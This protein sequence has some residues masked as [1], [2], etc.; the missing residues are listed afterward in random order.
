MQAELHAKSDSPSLGPAHVPQNMVQPPQ[1]Q[2]PIANRQSNPRKAN[3]AI[4]PKLEPSSAGTAPGLLHKSATSPKNRP[5]PSSLSDSPGNAGSTFS[6]APSDS[7]SMRGSL[8]SLARQQLG[9][10]VGQAAR[11]SAMQ[12]STPRSAVTAAGSSFYPTPAF[13]N[14][15]E[16]LGMLTGLT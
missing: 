16:Q 4:A 3:S 15:I 2:R 11:N 7:I 8:S 12:S 5:T 14:H 1:I 9:G 10:A 6:P 13:Q